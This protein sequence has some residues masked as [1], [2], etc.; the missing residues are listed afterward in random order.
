M[1]TNSDDIFDPLLIPSSPLRGPDFNSLTDGNTRLP[2]DSSTHR[3]SLLPPLPPIRSPLATSSSPRHH[4]SRPPASSPD[5]VR[6]AQEIVDEPNIFDLTPSGWPVDTISPGLSPSSEAFN[7]NSVALNL[8]LGSDFNDS[9]T[10]A[11]SSSHH[12]H[13]GQQPTTTTSPRFPHP[14]RST[15]TSQQT[16]SRSETQLTFGDDILPSQYNEIWSEPPSPAL[17]HLDSTQTSFS[18]APMPEARKRNAQPGPPEPKRQRIASGEYSNRTSFTGKQRASDLTWQQELFGETPSQPDRTNEIPSDG[19]QTIDLTEATSVPEELL[20][21][22]E[23]KRIKIGAFQCVICMDDVTTLTVT[24]CGHLYCAQCL[25]SSLHV[26]ATKGKCPMC[27]TKIETKP[28]ESYNSKTKGYWPLEL[29]LM[30]ARRKGK[31]KIDL[32]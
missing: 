9:I 14:S 17:S 11:P 21:P 8:Y 30:T 16:I 26:D 12:V 18:E 1:P 3:A 25:H 5:R 10:R 13:S 15:A 28:R 6:R 24:H 29:K 27:R 22:E 2:R 19:L 4:T 32:T 23:D 7:P 20:K 31:R